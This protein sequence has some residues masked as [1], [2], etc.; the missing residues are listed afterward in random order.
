MALTLEIPPQP[1]TA[2]VTTLSIY[3]IAKNA[4]LVS[5]AMTSTKRVCE[6]FRITENTICNHSMGS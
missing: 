4:P 5:S 6:A 2:V 3:D 1:T